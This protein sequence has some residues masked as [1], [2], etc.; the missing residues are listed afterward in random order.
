M[1]I[2]NKDTNLKLYSVLGIATSLNYKLTQYV[3]EYTHQIL[4]IYVYRKCI[5][6]I[7]FINKIL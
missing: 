6:T 7:H 4:S 5:F 3:T 2:N 1:Y